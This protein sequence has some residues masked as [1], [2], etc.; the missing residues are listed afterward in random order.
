MLHVPRVKKQSTLPT[1]LTPQ[2]VRRIIDAASNLKHKA[3]LSR[4]IQLAFAQ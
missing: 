1:I 3:I 4:F 2:E